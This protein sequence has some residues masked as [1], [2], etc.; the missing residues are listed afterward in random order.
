MKQFAKPLCLASMLTLS[1]LAFSDTV[2]G[3]YAGGG[4]WQSDFSGQV[5]DVDQPAADLED[6]GLDDQ[7]NEFY[8][9]ALEHP[10]PLLPN[11]RLQ[12][13]DVSL[14]ETSTISRS[15]VLDDVA[16]SINEQLV[17][18]FDFSH[19]DATFYYELL[20]N[21]VNLDLGLTFRKFDGDLSLRS[22]TTGETASSRLDE[23]VPLLYGKA[24]F[25]LPLTGFYVS[26]GGNFVSYDGS[27][28]SDL[29]AAVG[30]MSDG[31]LLDVG[32]EVGVRNFNIELDDVSDLDADMEL[33]GAFASVYLHF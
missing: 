19:T 14:S 9:V 11:I 16:Y 33:E 3:I 22:L 13:T 1:P 21:W 15:F 23:T 10:V 18:D 7:D 24:Q 29:Q 25:N 12:H 27:D 26:A 6:L 28:M 8:F 31:L 17:S 32:I 2:L 5:G 20:D 4:V 30:Y